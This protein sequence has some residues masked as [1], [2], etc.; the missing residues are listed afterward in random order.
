M[1]FDFQVLCALLS[2]GLVCC[3]LSS[4]FTFSEVRIKSVVVFFCIHPYQQ[5]HYE[6]LPIILATLRNKKR[7]EVGVQVNLNPLPLSSWSGL[8]GLFSLIFYPYR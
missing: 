6:L 2:C 5:R 3:T 1:R 7:G 8:I 4:G